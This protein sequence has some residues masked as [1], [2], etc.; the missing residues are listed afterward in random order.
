MPSPGVLTVFL[1][2]LLIFSASPLTCHATHNITSILASRRDLAEFSRQLTATGLADEIN[3]RNTITVLAVD[4]AHM[5]SLKARGLHREALRRVLSL[6]VLVDYYDDAKLHRL[7]GGS[8]VVSTLFQAS[9]DAPGSSG[10][11]KI[12]DRRGGRVAFLPQQQDEE[13]ADDAQ[14]AAVF[15]V[16]S[17][18]ETPYN[19]SVLQV[20][21]VISSPAAEAPSLPESARPNAT[22][23]MA[24]NGCGRFASLAAS[25]GAA[26][27]YEKTMANDGGLTIFCPGDDAM[28]AFMPAYRALS[29]DSQLAMLL[30]HGVARHYSLPALKAI[31][32]AMRTLAM[33]TGNNGNDN[34]KYVLTAREAGSTV[35]L[36]S[37][38]KEPATVT[39]TLMDA[40]PL[41]VY[42]VDAVLVPMDGSSSGSFDGTEQGGAGDGGGDAAAKKKNA[43]ATCRLSFV[44]MLLLGAIQVAA[45]V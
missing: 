36:L 28:K 17:V 15:Y 41:A 7:P 27:R 38:A 32:G 45:L 37:A 34:D 31:G 35:T 29:R 16:K 18:H 26:S 6:H 19:I 12:S 9:G 25:A 3:V 1:L 20:S 30:Y 40:D 44:L 39:G 42:I 24:R 14:A 43:A 4:D 5:S 33:D 10:M 22:D 23:V 21:A 13:A 2:L 11:V 8:A